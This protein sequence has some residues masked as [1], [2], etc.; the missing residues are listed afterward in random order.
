M[1]DWPYSCSAVTAEALKII[2]APSRHSTSVT[3]KS[4]RSFSSRL[5]IAFPRIHRFGVRT[6]LLA[7]LKMVD[8]LLENAPAVF[9]ILKLVKAR[10]SRRQQNNISGMRGVK[11]AIDRVLQST[12]APNRHT[13]LD[14]LFNFIGRRANQERE[15][16]LFTEGLWQLRV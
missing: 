1:Y 6:K 8:E 12:G 14:L 2:T 13:T 9:I 4:Q 15:N 16:R 10:A 3:M 7:L 5:G 11:C